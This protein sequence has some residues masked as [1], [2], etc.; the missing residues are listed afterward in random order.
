MPNPTSIPDITDDW[1]QLLGAYTANAG[2]L[3]SIE[4]LSQ[5]L[6]ATLT[7]VQEY[8]LQEKASRAE[9][10]QFTKKRQETI[11]RGK[12]LASRLRAG[13]KSVYGAKNEKLIEFGVPPFRRRTRSK[14]KEP[15]PAPAAALSGATES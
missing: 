14:E 15:Q 12:E 6:S 1:Q 3:Q 5:Q 9:R 7:E 11:A 10:Q 2:E 4:P 13:I 8:S